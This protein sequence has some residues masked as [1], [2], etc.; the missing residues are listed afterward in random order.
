MTG[1]VA[2]LRSRAA[3]EDGVSLTELIVTMMIMGVVL[4]IVGSMFVNVAEITA[5]SNATT[6]K[7]SVAA[8]IMDAVGEVVRTAA[9]N[10]I[11][12]SEDADPAIISGTGS[13]LTLYSFVDTSAKSPELSKVGYRVD[14]SGN[15]IEDRWKASVSQG[16]W[17]FSG[18]P[19]S[20]TLGGP[21]STAVGSTALFVYLDS[22]GAEIPFAATGLTFEQRKTVASIRV[23]VTMPNDPTTGSDPIVVVST[24]GMPNLKISR[25]ES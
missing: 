19:T 23:R 20:R 16:F 14:A 22:L 2:R 9:N 12:G 17:T 7:S 5:N 1:I 25:T 3:E 21:V 11:I 13:A 4:A 8:N 10:P 18:T 15:L 24:I 6:R